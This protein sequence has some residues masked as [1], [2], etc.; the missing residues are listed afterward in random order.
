MK[1]WKTSLSGFLA[2]VGASLLIPFAGRPEWLNV[3]APIMIAAGI[4]FGG[5]AQKDK[6]KGDK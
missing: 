2:S 5:L 4:F 6:T 3:V 1:D